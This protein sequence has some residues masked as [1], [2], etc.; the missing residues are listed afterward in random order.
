[1]QCCRNAPSETGLMRLKS[2]AWHAAGP[3]RRH[4]PAAWKAVSRAGYASVAAV[5]ALR[6]RH[7]N[8][9]VS[10]TAE[11]GAFRSRRENFIR[12]L[13][14]AD[15]VHGFS[16]AVCD[17]FQQHGARNDFVRITPSVAALAAIRPTTRRP[18][19]PLVFAF[20]GAFSRGKGAEVALRTFEGMSPGDAVLHI[21]GDVEESL[22]PGV[23]RAE[24]S[25]AV[26]Y[27]GRYSRAQLQQVLDNIDVAIMPAVWMEICSLTGLE[28]KAARIPIIA[29][30]I[31]GF[32]DYVADGRDGFLVPPGD[33]IALRRA[34][35]RFIANP[36]LVLQFRRRIA[37]VKDIGQHVREIEEL[38]AIPCTA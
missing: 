7:A 14:T 11:A 5:S 29:S 36:E 18:A 2:A 24:A 9:A 20:S 31:G 28:F 3:L 32:R 34:I 17:V 23:A 10:A 21:H 38:Y 16:T 13:N 27:C 1:V 26:R 33:A 8:G 30:D 35:D 12:L 25:G 19:H 4:A 22:R 37:P 6:A 15:V